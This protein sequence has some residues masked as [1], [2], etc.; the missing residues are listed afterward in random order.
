[1]DGGAE[2]GLIMARPL[3]DGFTKCKDMHQF[4]LVFFLVIPSRYQR[5]KSEKE[6]FW[7][8][9]SVFKKG[10]TNSQGKSTLGK[11]P[12]NYTEK[13]QSKD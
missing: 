1:V 6:A 7:G 12:C 3:V 2:V 13:N 4:F 8:R 11:V 10:P 9:Q 5:K